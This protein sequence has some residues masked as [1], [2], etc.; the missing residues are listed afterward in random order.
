[1]NCWIVNLNHLSPASRQGQRDRSFLVAEALADAGNKVIYYSNSYDA[2]SAKFLN[3]KDVAGDIDGDIKV[4]L[5]QA[6]SYRYQYSLA[7]WRYQKKLWNSFVQHAQEH[8]DPDVIILP[9]VTHAYFYSKIIAWAKAKHIRIVLDIQHVPSGPIEKLAY[10]WL[11]SSFVYADK[12]VVASKACDHWVKR[13]T[14]EIQTELL[15]DGVPFFNSDEVYATDSM[16]LLDGKVIGKTVFTCFLSSSDQK[17]L[18]VFADIATRLNNQEK[19]DIMLV[20]VT[21]DKAMWQKMQ[22]T[23]EQLS[24]VSIY[25]HLTAQEHAGLIQITDVGMSLHND[26]VDSDTMLFLSAGKPV[27]SANKGEVAELI[28]QH[29]IGL[30]ASMLDADALCL[31]MFYLHDQVKRQ[32]MSMH[33]AL[34]FSQQ[35]DAKKIYT[36]YAQQIVDLV[37]ESRKIYST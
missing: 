4:Q 36:V 37:K 2:S 32:T 17:Y 23:C 28:E 20:L 7:Y 15:Y 21:D 9:Y 14:P 30:S 8:D 35:F 33:A 24:H 18:N 13:V 16:V 34:L 5:L 11:K 3:N 10:Y 1:M 22:A 12:I 26:G 25:H 27:I 6:G 29:K 19:A 31:K